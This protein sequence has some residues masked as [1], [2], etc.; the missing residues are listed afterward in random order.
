MK[1]IVRITL[2]SNFWGS[3][4]SATMPTFRGAEAEGDACTGFA[5]R[6]QNSIVIVSSH[7]TDLDVFM[8]ALSIEL[9]TMKTLGDVSDQIA[10]YSVS[11][12][13]CD[14]WRIGADVARV[15]HANVRSHVVGSGPVHVRN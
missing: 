3:A 1:P 12:V 7:I 4:N 15:R 9:L 5:H 11:V 13:L 2:P 10:G 6:A 8:R 14:N